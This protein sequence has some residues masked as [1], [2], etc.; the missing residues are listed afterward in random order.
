MRLRFLSGPYAWVSLIERLARYTHQGA[1]GPAQIGI[2]AGPA[3]Q[4]VGQHCIGRPVK[5]G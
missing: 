2:G 4:Q 3:C 5:G 1:A